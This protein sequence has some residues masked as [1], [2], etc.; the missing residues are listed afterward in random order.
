MAFAAVALAVAI[1]LAAA[2]NLLLA[3]FNGGQALMNLV[4]W[5]GLR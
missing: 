2:V 3:A 1:L 5:G 4:K